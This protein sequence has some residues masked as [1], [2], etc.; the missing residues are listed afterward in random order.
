MKYY[1]WSWV[2]DNGDGSVSVHFET[3]EE[4]AI[5]AEEKEFDI[6]GYRWAESSVER[7]EIDI[8]DIETESDNIKQYYPEVSING[9]FLK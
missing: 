5:K 9:I 3:T 1:L 8:E 7:L 2:S 4:K 6:N